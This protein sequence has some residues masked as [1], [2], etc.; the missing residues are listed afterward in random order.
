M[1]VHHINSNEQFFD[2]IAT[3]VSVVDFFA[4]WYAFIFAAF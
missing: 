4:T 1:A 2:L 3:G